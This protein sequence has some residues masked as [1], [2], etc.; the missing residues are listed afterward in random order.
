[1]IFRSKNKQSS[2]RK[3]HISVFQGLAGEWYF[4]VHAK[5][6]KIVLQSEGYIEKRSAVKTAKRLV[7]IIGDAEVRVDD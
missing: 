6:G 7:Q 2:Q 4:N 5:N 1:M 3:P